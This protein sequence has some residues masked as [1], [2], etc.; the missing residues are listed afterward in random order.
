MAGAIFGAFDALYV[1]NLP[2]RADRRREM[3]AQLAK[4]G[5]ALDH[6]AVRVFPAIRPEAR[7]EFPSIG[8]RGC[9]LSHLALLRDA[10]ACGVERIMIAEDD[11]NFA[12]DFADR[13]TG[14]AR[15]LERTR[16][17]VFYGGHLNVPV[18][19]RPVVE[20]NAGERD[21]GRRAGGLRRPEAGRQGHA[22][23]G[24][25]RRR[26]C[27][28]GRVSGAG[29]FA[30]G[31][32]PAG[33]GRCMWTAPTAGGAPRI[34]TAGP[35]PPPRRSAIREARARTSPIPGGSIAMRC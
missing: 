26:H 19:E 3:A 11:L 17:D 18:I 12:R 32:R 15:T 5:L 2:E 8:A 22:F 24:L 35:T 14:I 7:G 9:F 23:S 31:R 1:I 20:R 10:E 13:I 30:P 4:V 25:P 34:P 33:G 29:G 16:W 21:G 6:P 28:S 27:R